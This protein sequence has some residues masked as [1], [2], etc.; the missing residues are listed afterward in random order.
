MYTSPNQ[1]QFQIHKYIYLKRGFNKIFELESCF[2]TKKH[3]ITIYQ[4]LSL[5]SY[6]SIN[7]R[8]EK[9]K[10]SATFLAINFSYE[11]YHH[12]FVEDITIHI[13]FSESDQ[14]KKLGNSC[15]QL[16]KSNHPTQILFKCCH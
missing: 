6:P 2:F 1:D 8:S 12:Q 14:I 3:Y 16:L 11:A 13:C 15:D 10:Q 9:N 5:P 4:F 7:V